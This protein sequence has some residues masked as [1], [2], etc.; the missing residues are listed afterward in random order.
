MTRALQAL[1]LAGIL[2]SGAA[3]SAQQTRE[4]T[5]KNQPDRPISLTGCVEKGSTPSQ[6]TITD[7]Q[8]GKYEVSGSNIARYVGRRVQVAG[9]AGSS[10]FRVVGGLWPNPNVAAQAGDMDPA[11]AALAT[12]PGGPYSGTGEVALPTFKVKSVRTMSGACE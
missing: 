2:A 4:A 9:S 8:N 3:A 10:R 1:L 7:M 12:Q 5:P 11:K 6:Y